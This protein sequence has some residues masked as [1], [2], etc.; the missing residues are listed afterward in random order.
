MKRVYHIL[1][2]TTGSGLTLGGEELG[3]MPFVFDEEDDCK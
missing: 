2:T 1:L 3:R